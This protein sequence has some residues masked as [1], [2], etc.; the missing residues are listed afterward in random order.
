MIPVLFLISGLAA[1]LHAGKSHKHLSAH[2]H[3]E[4]KLDVSANKKDLLLE[5]ESPAE[6][7]LGF[8]HKA[9]NPKEKSLVAKVKEN[10]TARLLSRFSLEDC[11]V[12][13][14]HWQQKFSGKHHSAIHANAHVRCPKNLTGRKLE[15]SLKK[16][17]PTINAIHLR[18]VGDNNLNIKRE[19]STPVFKVTLSK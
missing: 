4:V 12:I 15:I 2:V 5:M 16:D 8:E 7:F 13:Q 19:F 18:L 9:R 17:Y 14:S 11:K 10:W 6:S 1:N 3:G